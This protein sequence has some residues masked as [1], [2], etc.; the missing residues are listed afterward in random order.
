W[1]SSP[2]WGVSGDASSALLDR[3]KTQPGLEG[4][5]VLLGGRLL[6]DGQP[7]S[8]FAENHVSGAALTPR[9]LRGRLPA[10][11]SEIAL[12]ELTARDGGIAVG[13]T[14][15]LS[16]LDATVDGTVVGI[17]VVPL[18]LAGPDAN[19]PGRGAF[20]TLDGLLRV[21]PEP[22]GFISLMTYAPNADA[23]AL[24]RSL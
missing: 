19:N 15:R 3:T 4:F 12:G 7:S 24:E 13:D 9:L 8:I 23:A 14:V 16:T 11:D 18:L 5:G 21:V 17:V 2:E 1:S 20:V 22:A 6:I 10:T